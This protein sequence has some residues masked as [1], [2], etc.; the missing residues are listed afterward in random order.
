M[1][2]KYLKKIHLDDNFKQNTIIK[3]FL[4]DIVKD[5]EKVIY[6][7]IKNLIRKETPDKIITLEQDLNKRVYK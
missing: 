6:I 2:K 4:D 5:N 7:L 3:I 1:V